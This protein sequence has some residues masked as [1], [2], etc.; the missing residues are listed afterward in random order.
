MKL[1][2][3]RLSAPRSFLVVAA[4]ACA[5][6]KLSAADFDVMEKSILEL[7]SAMQGGAV[8]SRQLV[9]LYLARIAAYDKQGPT[10]N[11]ITTTN[12]QA[13][14]AAEALDQER[15]TRGA[16]G[17][18]HGI[19]I[20][21]KDNYETIEMPTSDGSIALATFHPKS[22]AFMVQ[23]LKQ[24]GAVVLGKTNMHELAMGITSVGSLFGRVRNPYDLDRN[25]GGSS[26]GTG[27]AIAANFAAAGLGSDTCGSIR[28]PS[29]HNNL[30]G[31]RGTQG[32]SSRIGIIPLSSTQDIGGPL[33]RSI[34]D[35]ALM[36]E[37][38]VGVDPA[39]PV[40]R[41]SEGRVPK[42]Y[43]DA[44]D[45]GALKGARLGIVRSL[46]GAAP[47]D[48][49]VTDLVNKW[50][51]RLRQAGA[52]LVDVAI[53]GLDD[54]LKDSTV[55]D[56]EFKFDFAAYLARHPDAPIKSL[57]EILE[58][59]LY[60][61]ELEAGFRKR[62]AP[63]K[64][65]T[66]QYR[67]A[68][69]KRATTRQAVE[70][71]MDEHRVAALVYPTLRRKPARIGE[72][73]AGSNC[74]LSATSGLPALAVPIGLTNDGLPIGVDLLG[75]AFSE[76]KLLSLGY[77]IEQTVQPRKP[78]FSTPA[79]NDGKTPAPKSWTTKLPVEG[80]ERVAIDWSY[81]A[82][83]SRLSYR[84]TAA[85]RSPKE[86]LAVW[87]HRGTL[88]KSE[89]ALHLLAGGAAPAQGAVTL[90]FSDRAD[91]GAGRLH[92]R[93]YTTQQPGGLAPVPLVMP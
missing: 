1:E 9:E 67:R 6:T 83:T 24:A 64:R 31:L 66:E 10:L 79:L 11:A 19:P 28:N 26:G 46:F 63:E 58:R 7:Q 71:A 91:L 62:N 59:G 5:L 69:I 92:V 81:D 65:E 29:S 75:A 43:R 80:S 34:T 23:R 13:L 86:L 40:T 48:Q 76:A 22:D 44:L 25:P 30:F 39:D 12:P 73:Q 2:H 8:T 61:R 51:E 21:V 56:A 53:P 20:L 3:G 78:P 38:T 45:R 35:L 82:T 37:A 17:P 18:L 74:Q 15:R 27:A 72:A 55:I 57:A 42:S 14:A 77:A 68:L 93:V 33:A 4:F 50:L 87:I 70:A 47:E 60:H 52:E 32:L 54:L 89:A 84:M 49:E 85:P 16:R 88:P 36:L 41:K 90:S